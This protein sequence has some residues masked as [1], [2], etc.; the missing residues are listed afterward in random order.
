[1]ERIHATRSRARA[2]A[3]DGAVHRYLIGT[4]DF[5]ETYGLLSA[6]G[7]YGKLNA[8]EI[9][10]QRAMSEKSVKLLEGASGLYRKSQSEMLRRP[11][12]D[13]PFSAYVMASLRLAELGVYRRFVNG[14]N[15]GSKPE[16]ESNLNSLVICCRAL[17]GRLDSDE[18]IK[19]SDR[20]Q[21]LKYLGAGAI[22]A[23]NRIHGMDDMNGG[24]WDARLAI[25]NEMKGGSFSRYKLYEPFDV[26]IY[27]RISDDAPADL[28]YRVKYNE[29]SVDG[30][31]ATLELDD[32]ALTTGGEES[33]KIE[34]FFS[35][36]LS[37]GTAVS[38][39][40]ASMLDK[41]E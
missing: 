10:L 7:G 40:I 23:L 13:K 9:L 41:L 20:S 27:S 36:C 15:I 16:T 2:T 21:S 35:N 11:F 14:E 31:V 18:S 37:P 8:A 5:D 38:G 39:S 30:S 4:R 17:I 1:M 28:S 29:R 22:V 34:H 33:K 26:A 12:T 19:P 24:S 3:V 6:S 32:F 25:V